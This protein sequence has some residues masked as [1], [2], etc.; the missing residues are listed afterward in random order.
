MTTDAPTIALDA[1]KVEWA[2]DDSRN[3][4]V[5]RREK[6]AKNMRWLAENLNRHAE[7]L[8]A[9]DDGSVKVHC[10]NSLGEVQGHGA[11]IDNECGRLD[12]AEKHVQALGFALRSE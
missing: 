5:H 7:E 10:Y 4:V 9:A 12:E 11:S 2:V 6:L 8:E 3:N 1:R